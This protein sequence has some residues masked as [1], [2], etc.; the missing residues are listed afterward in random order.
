MKSGNVLVLRYGAKRLARKTRPLVVQSE[1][2]KPKAVQSWLVHTRFPALWVSFFFT[3][4]SDWST[5]WYPGVLSDW[6]EWLLFNGVVL[7]HFNK[8]NSI[9]YS[10]RDM[11]AKV[12]FIRIQELPVY[13][14]LIS[15]VFPF[16]GLGGTTAKQR[17]WTAT[18]ENRIK[19]KTR[20]GFG[21]TEERAGRS[22]K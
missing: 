3:S 17:V 15:T 10:S 8:R 12:S 19:W 2:V 14:F 16:I 9:V 1:V 5:H 4:I 11:S 20:E 13:N 18:I 7:R 21:R 22:S 6:R